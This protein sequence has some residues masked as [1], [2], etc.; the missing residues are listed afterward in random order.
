[1]DGGTE[2]EKMMMI[3]GRMGD[4]ANEKELGSCFSLAGWLLSNL[5]VILFMEHFRNNQTKNNLAPI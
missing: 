3:C 4:R 5:C 2:A 1:M